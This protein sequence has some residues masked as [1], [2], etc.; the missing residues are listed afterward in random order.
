M[1]AETLHADPTSIL[2]LYRT[3]LAARRAS[4]ALHSGTWELLRVD[5]AV[6]AYERRLGDDVRRVIANF[7]E[8]AVDLPTDGDWIVEV[9]S[10]TVTSGIAWTGALGPEEA[11]LLSARRAAARTRTP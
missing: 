7:S 3:L 1:L 8:T 4:P 5:E 9:H 11:V 2:W 6:Y 10:T